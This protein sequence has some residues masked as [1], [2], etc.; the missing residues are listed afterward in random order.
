MSTPIQT[1]IL[2]LIGARL[3]LIT[4]ANNYFTDV[5]KVERARLQPF[6][7]RDMPAINYYYTGDSLTSTLSNGISER[8]VAIVIEYYESTR[9]EIFVDLAD[10][11][12]SDVLISLER[13]IAA[14]L[15]ADPV[16]SRLGGVVMRMEVESVTPAIG[17]GQSPYC[18][19]V[20]Q[21]NIF[22]RVARQSPFTLIT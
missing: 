3:A 2:D 19:T 8:S 6:K 9:D 21:L 18:G 5:V 10:K 16:S 14:P 22:Y 7:N 4:T 12:T 1:Q 15:V 17:E 20:I 13:T 11:L